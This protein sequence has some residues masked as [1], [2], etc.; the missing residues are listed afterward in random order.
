MIKNAIILIYI[1]CI[2][3]YGQCRT[4]TKGRTIIKDTVYNKL[5]VGMYP[6]LLYYDGIIDDNTWE[7]VNFFSLTLQPYTAYNLYKNLYIGCAFSYEFFSSN[8]YDKKNFIEVG[9][10]LRYVVPY[11]INKKFLRRIHIYSA[12]EYYKTNYRIV[13]EIV[14]TIYYKGRIMVEEDYI[15]SNKLDQSKIS[16]PVGLLFTINKY[17]Y[18]DLNWQNVKYLNGT[19]IDGF[20]CGIGINIRQKK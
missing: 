10:F 19:N 7:K 5:A 11:T 8:F 3:L 1:L 4:I 12:I 15:I 13:P 18:I 16:I 17:F 2:S 6:N 20:M 14:N 9:M